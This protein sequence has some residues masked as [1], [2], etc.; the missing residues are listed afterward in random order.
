MS[1]DNGLEAEN[2]VSEADM[3]ELARGPI[4]KV[5]GFPPGNPSHISPGE[6]D[7]RK[8]ESAKFGKETAA[9]RAWARATEHRASKGGA[10][11]K[12]PKPSKTARPGQA[13]DFA[14]TPMASA[15]K[16]NAKGKDKKDL[17]KWSRSVQFAHALIAMKLQQQ[18]FAIS[19]EESLLL[20]EAVVDLLEHYN[21]KLKGQAGAWG[22]LAYAVG[23]IYG[24]R[25]AALIM[26]R[27]QSNQEK[28]A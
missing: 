7:L 9:T 5:T 20:T 11:P 6:A 8:S 14:E 4:G 16:S 15:I 17:E 19:E 26:K 1:E 10:S 23:M 28:A 25:I 22:G 2:G 13:T 27:I 18:D 21:I 12:N 24:P 3:V